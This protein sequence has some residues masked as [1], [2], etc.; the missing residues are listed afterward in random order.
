MSTLY[1][2][3]RTPEVDEI[4]IIP[5][6]NPSGAYIRIDDREKIPVLSHVFRAAH[7]FFIVIILVFT[8]SSVRSVSAEDS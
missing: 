8:C 6:A 3:A 7:P 4:I 2:Y 1:N 5:L